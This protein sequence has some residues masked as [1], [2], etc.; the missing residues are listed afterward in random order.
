M[1]RAWDL[2]QKLAIAV[3]SVL[4]LVV[5]AAVW[6]D[7][8]GIRIN[9]LFPKAQTDCPEWLELA[10]PSKSPVNI[11]NWKYGHQ[12]DSCLITAT[13]FIVPANEFVVLARDKTLFSAK[14]PATLPVIQPV[15]WR[16]LDNYHDTLYMWDSSGVLQE[17]AGWDYHWFDS[18]TDQPLARVSLTTSGLLPTAWVVASKASPGQPNSEAT[19]RSGGATLEIG[20]IPFTPNGDGKDDFLSI[21]VTLPAGVSAS[22]SIYGFDG[23]KYLDLPQPPEKQFLWNGTAAGGRA[24]P[25][26]PFFVVLET[27]DNGSRKVI[28]KKGVVWR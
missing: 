11:K 25:A 19:W 28:R 14:F 27:S 9:E 2:K 18:W 8:S 22:V 10:N 5:G 7:D 26:G 13:D 16:A 15:Q 12:D 20:P 1:Y 23:R 17:S 21:S 6:G 24:V 3:A 4:W